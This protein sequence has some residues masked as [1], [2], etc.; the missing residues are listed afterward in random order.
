M[1]ADTL[2]RD[3]IAAYRQPV[4]EVL[5]ALRTD[6]HRGLTRQEAKARLAHYGRNELTADKPVPAWKQFLTQFQDLL[7]ILLLIATGPWRG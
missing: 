4:H 3:A 1:S 6:G 5:A 2:Q 7:V